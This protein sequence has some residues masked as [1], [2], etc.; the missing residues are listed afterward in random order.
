M[1]INVEDD[2]FENILPLKEEWIKI[3]DIPKKYLIY[4]VIIHLC[5][6]KVMKKIEPTLKNKILAQYVPY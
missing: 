6:D 3:N 2:D 1:E 5:R 4:L